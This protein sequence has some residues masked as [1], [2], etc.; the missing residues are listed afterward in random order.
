MTA[1]TTPKNDSSKP[2]ASVD[3][4]ALSEREIEIL[5]LV[6]TG[7]SNKQIAQQLVISTNTV[8]VHLRNI[9]AKIGAASRTE[10]TLYAI[11]EGLIQVDSATG[12]GVET[13][14]ASR[15]SPA[16]LA[17]QEQIAIP[18]RTVETKKKSLVTKV[19]RYGWIVL[20]L[21]VSLTSLGLLREAQRV[22]MATPS[23]TPTTPPPTAASRWRMNADMPT[24]RSGLAVATYENRVYA[25]GG[26]T[27]QG[28]IARTERYDPT[29]NAW[30]VLAPKPVAVADVNAA[31]IG[32]QIYVPGGRSASGTVANILEVYDP[33]LNQWQQRAPLPIPLSA[34]ALVTFEGRLYIFGGWDGQGYVATVYVYDPSRDTWA[35]NTPMTTARGYAGAAM[36]GGKIYV[37]GGTDGKQA[38]SINEEYVPEKEA[39][40]ANPWRQRAP[41]PEGRYGIGIVSIAD[42]I[43]IIGGQSNVQPP[44]PPLEYF[45]QN[46]IW[47][48][49]ES[50]P[51]PAW[52]KMGVAVVETDLLAIGGMHTTIP[53][54][55]NLAYKAVY[56]IIIAPPVK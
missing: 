18:I 42:I 48:A 2:T 5:R 53:S 44:L 51:T 19:W 56:T 37:I 8:K 28:V 24:A 54:S 39:E 9:F 16:I 52:S 41:L 55:R 27:I 43:H 14:S 31:V 34:Y 4:A 33:R 45:P 11:R 1:N 25:I 47:Q 49:F 12:S 20:G 23:L 50:P 15:D 35:E 32:G 40:R 30:T 7:A 13:V 21:I 26:E 17:V 46:D 6:A 3:K 10:A 36:A 22:S 38:L 29:S